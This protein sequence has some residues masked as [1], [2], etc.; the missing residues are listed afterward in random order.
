MIFLFNARVTD[1]ENR[2]TNISDREYEPG[3]FSLER[4]L[5]GISLLYKAGVRIRLAMYRSGILKSKKLS[6]PVISIGNITAG[7][8]GKTPMTLYL[9]QLVMDMGYRPVVV[10]RGYGGRSKES[11]AVVGDG[12]RIFMDATAAGDEPYMMAQYKKF[13]VVVGKRRYAA[14]QLAIELFDPDLIIL[15]DAFQHLALS[16]D[17]NLV[18]FD[19]DRPVGNGRMLPAGRLRE[20][21]NMAQERIHAIVF[22]RCPKSAPDGP[23]SKRILDA[24]GEGASKIPFYYTRHSSFLSGY[25][26]EGSQA[27]SVLP[28][29]LKALKGRK[30]VLFSGISQNQSFRETVAR[31]GIKVLS[32]LEF[33]DHYRY[34][35][36]D[37]LKIRQEAAGL[38]ADL[39]L[40]TQKDWV[41][42][43]TAFV[44]G[45]DLAVVGIQI[46]FQK[47]ELFYT[48]IRTLI[49]D[50]E[51][52]TQNYTK[53]VNP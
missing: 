32:H 31:W 38:A 35:R 16:R 3:A 8:S 45:K 48:V 9:A 33:A 51:K 49:R 2:I 25:Y 11:A 42:V 53:A 23:G 30:A 5:V 28:K 39:I 26:P 12:R 13:P 37:F 20:T 18:L 44:W 24:F 40:T 43:E 10:S 7:G 46:S 6:C 4:L 52:N 19:H 34:N 14:G 50:I 41:K 21:F 22:T 36:A 29:S 15:D 1:L 27:K 17:Y 47:P